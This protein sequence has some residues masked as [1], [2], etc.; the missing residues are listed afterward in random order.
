M[1]VINLSSP[2]FFQN[3]VGGVSSVIGYADRSNRVVR[4]SFVAPSTGASGVSLSIT[5]LVYGDGTRPQSFRFY[6]GTD[7][8]SHV[9]AGAGT[10]CT[11]ILNMGADKVSFSGSAS[12]LLLPNTT[13]YLFLFPNTTEYGW[14]SMELATTVLDSTGG[15]YSVPTLSASTVTMGQ[16]LTIYTNRHA[17]FTHTITYVFGNTSGAIAEGVTDSCTW[18]PPVELARQ[19][20]NAVTGVGSICCTT[21]SGGTQIGSTQTVTIYLTVP[22]TVVPTADINWTDSAGA[23]D[24]LGAYVQ[25]VTK[26]AVSVTGTGAYGSTV[27]GS[28]LTLD[29]KPYTGGVI[30]ADGSHTLTATV[31][32]SRGRRGSVSRSFTV[33]AY[34]KPALTLTASRCDADG[35]ADD[36]GE[37]SMVSITGS[38]TPVNGKN[39][40]AL[41]FTYGGTTKSI[42]VEVGDF[43]HSEIVPAPSTETL[44]LTAVLSDALL[45]V[46]RNM[47]LSVGYATMD[48][49]K[50]GRGIAMGTT[51][52]KE[53]FTC[54]MDA[55]FLGKVKGTIFDAIYPVG[56]IYM[57]VNDTNP[58]ALFGGTWEAIRGRFLM[59]AADGYPLGAEGG[60]KL[61]H[62][63]LAAS[64]YGG[65][66]AGGDYA[67]RVL[68]T[69][70]NAVNSN[71]MAIP[72]KDCG[73]DTLPP[74]LAVNIW[75]RT[76]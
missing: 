13:Y 6:I 76:A 17:G 45:T 39:T 11:G 29:G 71:T 20:P 31:T 23:Y 1:A 38:T 67:G 62:V 72:L 36:T 73:V 16:A 40:A 25:N 68:V 5:G 37:Y 69:H 61:D 44:A 74:Y 57:S 34:E 50:G 28:A 70:P 30:T 2:A 27:T 48:F 3:G 55:E 26:L 56:S 49:L 35:N 15:S 41:A 46:S 10:G 65:I 18:T 32:D 75:K 66:T 7:P 53:G 42:P 4:Y 59:G 9:S 12:I 47:T 14:F 8:N 52:T 54:A 63:F 21:Y 58:A 22:V 33:A 64:Q 43:V 24:K 51:A 19:I 60:G